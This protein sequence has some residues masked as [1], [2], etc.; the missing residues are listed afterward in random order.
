MGFEAEKP[1]GLKHVQARGENLLTQ[2]FNLPFLNIH[3]AILSKHRN[4]GCITYTIGKQPCKVSLPS[5]GRIKPF[6]SSVQEQSHE[7]ST[8]K[9]QNL[10]LLGK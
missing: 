1:R 5:K 8:V 2:E 10:V 3:T 4:G 6:N 9:Q 7:V